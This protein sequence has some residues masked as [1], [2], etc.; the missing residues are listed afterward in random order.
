M[1]AVI[2]VAV[3]PGGSGTPIPIEKVSLILPMC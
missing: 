3:Y 2:E 1:R